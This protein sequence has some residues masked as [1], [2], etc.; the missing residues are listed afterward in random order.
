MNP[1]DQTKKDVLP[2]KESTPKFPVEKG[3]P[4]GES[5][6]TPVT[7]CPEKEN[8]SPT[9]TKATQNGELPPKNSKTGMFT[10]PYPIYNIDYN[11]VDDLT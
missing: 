11:I 5:K 3:R 8:R 2:L 9:A 10:L 4:S 7:N 1:I 6:N